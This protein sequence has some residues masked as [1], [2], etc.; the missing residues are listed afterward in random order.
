MSVANALIGRGEC[1]CGLFEGAEAERLIRG[2]PFE[3]LILREELL[4]VA[5]HRC[6]D[7]VVPASVDAIVEVARE[8]AELVVEHGRPVSTGR[9]G[10]RRRGAEAREGRLVLENVDEVMVA[11][12]PMRLASSL[13]AEGRSQLGEIGEEGG[14]ARTRWQLMKHSEVSSMTKRAIIPPL[15]PW[16]PPIPVLTVILATSRRLADSDVFTKMQLKSCRCVKG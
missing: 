4:K 8:D 14:S 1:N 3:E 2:E 16:R 9:V 7:Y 12:A 6:S 15:L 10:A 5:F 11:L 13:R